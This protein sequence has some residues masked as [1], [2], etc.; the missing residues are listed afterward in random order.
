M[1]DCFTSFA[2]YYLVMVHFNYH[3]GRSPCLCVQAALST[4]N[5][6]LCQK[7]VLHASDAPLGL[8]LPI[9][10]SGNSARSSEMQI[11]QRHSVGKA[12]VF[13]LIHWLT[14]SLWLAIML[15]ISYSST[16]KWG[17]VGS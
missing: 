8:L 3:P 10:S 11:S 13:C 2:V 17:A 6:S 7:V 12:G 5:T 9:V 1:P 4:T 16:E 15:V 14:H